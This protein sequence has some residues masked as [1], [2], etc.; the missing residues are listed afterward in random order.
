MAVQVIAEIGSVHDGSYGNACK[1]IELAK[2]LG[3]DAVKFQTHLADAE[4]LPNAPSPA[5][6]SGEPRM[7]YFRRTSFTY[8][9]WRRLRKHADQVGITFVSSPF[10]LE[11]VDLLESI[12]LPFYK[13]PSG[14]VTNLPLLEKIAR[15]G[16]PCVVSSGMSTWEELD[17]AVTALKSGGALTVMQC[18]SAYPCPPERVGLNVLLEMKERYGLPVGLSDHTRGLAAAVAAVSFG[19]TMLEKHL[20]FSRSMYGSD[21]PHSMEPLEFKAFVEAIRETSVMFANPV[22]KSNISDYA[23]MK[24]IFEKSLVAALPL[25]KGTILKMEHLAFKKPGD[26]IKASN[27]KN[28]LG[29]TIVHDLPVN[30]KFVMEDFA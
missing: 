25:P 10:S 11:A 26:G 9:Q 2:S 12:G 29:R 15:T 14:E 17:A 4:S 23:E 20:S 7:D 13:I 19:A 3:A 1:L 16:K 27:Y 30:H 6:F 22:D 28:W 8:E 18:S 5:Y 21:A 24:R